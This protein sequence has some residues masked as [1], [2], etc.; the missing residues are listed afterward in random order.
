MDYPI[1][2]RTLNEKVF[3]CLKRQLKEH[4]KIDI[5]DNL[6]S[7]KMLITAARSFY[8][9]KE[10]HFKKLQLSADCV[11]LMMYYEVMGE[12]VNKIYDMIEE[13]IGDEKELRTSQDA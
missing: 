1:D 8:M 13:L 5:I 4:G 2:E 12:K 11:A 10:E 9:D 3:N 6:I 7:I